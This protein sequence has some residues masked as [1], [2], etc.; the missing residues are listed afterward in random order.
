MTKLLFRFLFLTFLA[1]LT[2]AGCGGSGSSATPSANGKGTVKLSVD[3]QT[4]A[5]AKSVLAEPP[6][7]I[8]AATV[9]LT[10][11][12]YQDITREM[13]ISSNV[14]SCQIDN[15]DQGYWHV[16][17]HIFSGTTEI[18]NGSSDAN[19]LAGVVSQV[20][21]LFDPVIPAPTQG[22]IALTAGI[23][24]MPGYTVINQ[25][26][27]KAFVD[28][29]LG[30]LYIYD[31]TTKTVGVYT[32]DT[33]VRTQDFTLAAA[34]TAIAMTAGNDAMLLG[35]TSGQIYRLDLTSG[36]T[37]LVGDVLMDVKHIVALDNRIALVDSLASYQSTLKTLDLTTGQVLGT[38]SYYYAFGDYLLNPA[39]GLVYAQ[40]INVSPVD[41][42]RIRVDMTSGAINEIVD[43]TYHGS[44]YLGEPIRLI[45]NGSRLA[46]ASGALFS[47]STVAAEDLLYSGSLGYAYA[48]LAADDAKNRLY[49]LNNGSPYKLLILNQDSYFL[50]TTAELLGTPKKLFVTPAKI[51]V[52]TTRDSNYYARAFDKAALGL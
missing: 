8:T 18:Y 2:L 39:N 9:T 21:L 28:P 40:D 5:V 12:G 29:A 33:L 19:V 48:D 51:I 11:D 52:L 35:Y 45:K 6:P 47:S 22:S 50:E 36:A 17:V 25:Q 37:T 16:A 3:L 14:A 42:F 32:A 7:T 13:T 31:A 15:L 46:T 49:L 26:V 1:L 30:K 10:R 4:L 38:K 43:S 41:L 24:P 34:P 20:N 44:Y 27:T 23:N